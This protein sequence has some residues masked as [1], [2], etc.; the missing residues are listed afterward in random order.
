MLP[1]LPAGCLLIHPAHEKIPG[2]ELAVMR[3]AAELHVNPEGVILREAIRLMVKQ[4][5]RP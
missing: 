2:P 4:K 3:M 5:H 1:P